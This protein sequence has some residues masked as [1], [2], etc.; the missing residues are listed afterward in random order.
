MRLKWRHG[1]GPCSFVHAWEDL[2]A[3]DAD[4]WRTCTLRAQVVRLSSQEL[5]EIF[6]KMDS[7]GDGQISQIEFIKGL[8]HNPQLAAQLDLPSSIHQVWPLRMANA[9][10]VLAL[11]V[12][13]VVG[14]LC[15]L[16]RV[17]AQRYVCCVLACVCASARLL[18]N[19]R[20]GAA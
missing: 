7:N 4:P 8:R 15:C 20:P 9:L 18:P 5:R 17:G 6:R 14:A 10:L 19:R 16:W 13:C 2:V 3:A 12:P 1:V 11:W